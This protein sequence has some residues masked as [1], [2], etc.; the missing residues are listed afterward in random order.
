MS[1]WRPAISANGRWVAFVST[2][3]NLVF[4]DDN[5]VRDVFIHD[6]QTGQT[7]LVSIS[8]AGT[9]GNGESYWDKIDVSADGRYVAF[10]SAASNLVDKDTNDAFD[11]FVRDRLTNQT[12]RISRAS[13]GIEGNSYSIFPSISANGFSIAYMSQADNLVNGDTN[14][15]LDVFVCDLR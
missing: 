12:I 13:D 14:G 10:E 6:L 8:S 11:I 4:Y 2:S 5:W 9:Q 7:N 15:Y 1:S 3:D